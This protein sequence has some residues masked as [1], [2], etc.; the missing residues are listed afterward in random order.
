[1]CWKGVMGGATNGTVA[2]TDSAT[3]GGTTLATF[4]VP[5]ITTSGTTFAGFIPIPQIDTDG[6]LMFQNGVAVVLTT[7]AAATVIF[8]QG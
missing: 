3:T 4:D 8:R 1:M 5:G 2:L 6:G 7:A